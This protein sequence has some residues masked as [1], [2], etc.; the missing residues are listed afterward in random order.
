[1]TEEN[2]EIISV[3][4]E[5]TSE[6]IQETVDATSK[7]L[8]DA[9]EEKSETISE[10]AELISEEISDDSKQKRRKKGLSVVSMIIGIVAIVLMVLAIFIWIIKTLIIFVPIIRGVVLMFG[11]LAV[12]CLDVIVFVLSLFA[13]L[14]GILGIKK[15]GRNKYAVAGRGIGF[16]TGGL[17]SLKAIGSFIL[18]AAIVLYYVISFSVSMIFGL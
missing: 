7:E 9:S 16:C 5:S 8:S 15:E 18:I 2:N 3:G 13:I 11:T 12:L 6:E 4:A 14:F 17:I 1:M 10:T